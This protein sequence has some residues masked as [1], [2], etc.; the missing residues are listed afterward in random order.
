MTIEVMKELGV[1]ISHQRSKDIQEFLGQAFDYVI[2]VC[3]RAR[4]SCPIFPE[5]L[6][7]RYWSFED[8]AA[9]PP[10][11]QRVVFC[12]VRDEIMDRICQFLVE[13]GGLTPDALQCYRC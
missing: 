7:V 8:P 6:N 13:E 3:D 4:E 5:A 1:N 2:T 12:R 11:T 9:A 10:E